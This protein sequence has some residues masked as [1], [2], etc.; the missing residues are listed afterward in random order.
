MKKGPIHKNKQVHAPSAE[1]TTAVSMAMVGDDWMAHIWCERGAQFEETEPVKIQTY[2]VFT[3]CSCIHSFICVPPSSPVVLTCW[4]RNYWKFY[5][6][7]K[8][9]K[10][11]FR[12]D[13]HPFISL[14]LFFETCTHLIKTEHGRSNSHLKLRCCCYDVQFSH[15]LLWREWVWNVNGIGTSGVW[16]RELC[17]R[18]VSLITT[19]IPN[20]GCSTLLLHHMSN[21]SPNSS[22]TQTTCSFKH[23][24]WALSALFSPFLEG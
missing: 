13:P 17:S 24:L 4:S 3:F 5:V 20:D 16:Q 12:S 18:A 15:L 10:W 7:K 9:K 2:T 21:F 8:K 14:S 1:W 22:I 11:A 19:D 23:Y 6:N